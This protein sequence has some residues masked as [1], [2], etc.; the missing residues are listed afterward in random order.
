MK[1]KREGFGLEMKTF[2]GADGNSYLVF[3]TRNGSFHAFMEV[4]AK[5]AARQCGADGDK[6]TRGLWAELWREAD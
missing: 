6:N 2:D 3:R 5:E 1:E 4:E